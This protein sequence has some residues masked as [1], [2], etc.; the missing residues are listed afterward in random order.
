MLYDNGGQDKLGHEQ[1]YKLT[2]C[3]GGSRHSCRLCKCERLSDLRGWREPPFSI[4]KKEVAMRGVKIRLAGREIHL[5]F[6]GAAMFEL[7]TALGGKSVFEAIKST[8]RII[9]IIYVRSLRS[10]VSRASSIADFMGMTN[11]RSPRLMN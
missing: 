10:W 3:N 4:V 7:K 5:L 6:N 9:L 1:K 2:E 11:N 8:D